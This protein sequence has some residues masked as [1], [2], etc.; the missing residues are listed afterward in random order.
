M[1]NANKQLS[2]IISKKKPKKVFILARAYQF[3]DANGN[4]EI[5]NSANGGSSAISANY[6][7]HCPTNR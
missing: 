2:T 5:K 6:A 7:N 4:E 1:S 3:R